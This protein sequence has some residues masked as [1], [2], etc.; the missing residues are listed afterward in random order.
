MIDCILDNPWQF[1]RYVRNNKPLV[2]TKESIDPWICGNH[3]DRCG[4]RVSEVYEI[5]GVPMEA[6]GP[7]CSTIEECNS[8]TF[9]G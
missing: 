5:A 9:G 4:T 6:N 1:A 8:Q 2:F 7:S 3:A